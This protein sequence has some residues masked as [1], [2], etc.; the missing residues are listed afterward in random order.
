LDDWVGLLDLSSFTA[1][2]AICKFCGETMNYLPIPDNSARQLIDSMTIFS[3][4]IRVKK[5]AEKY[6]GHMYWKSENGY[7]YLVK[8]KPRSRKQERLGPKSEATEKIFSEFNER[9]IAIESRLNSLKES[10]REAERLNKALKVGRVPNLVVDILS[11]LDDLGLSQHFTVVGTHA[12]YAYELAAGVR[13]IPGALATQDVDLL[14]DARKR[15]QF[16]LDMELLD[17]SMIKVLKKADPTFVRKEGQNET[18]IN[19]KGFEVDFLRRQPIENDPHPFR[20]SDDE[21]DLWPVQENRASVLT[22]APRFEH[23]VIS[24]TGR[25]ALMSTI[26]PK[27]FIEFKLWMAENAPYRDAVKK[28]RDKL[29]A[30]IVQELIEQG[31]LIS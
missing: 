11:V 17:T 23:V 19:D 6:S 10:M 25:M 31:F 2:N 28:R 13:I 9:K 14:W 1:N 26:S 30:S 27:S 21:N 5:Q 16:L 20:F 3:E 15:V 7:E 4:F 29:Q 24:S 22:V 18:A 12:L 8:T